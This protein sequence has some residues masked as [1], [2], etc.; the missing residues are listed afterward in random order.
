MKVLKVV[1]N[2]IVYQDSPMILRILFHSA[3]LKLLLIIYPFI[4]CAFH[5]GVETYFVSELSILITSVFKHCHCH[6]WNERYFQFIIYFEMC[7]CI[8]FHGSATVMYPVATV[9]SPPHV[10]SGRRRLYWSFLGVSCKA[11]SQICMRRKLVVG[12]CQNILGYFVKSHNTRDLG[13]MVVSCCFM[14]EPHCLWSDSM[15]QALFAKDTTSADEIG[16]WPRHHLLKKNERK[17]WGTKKE[18]AWSC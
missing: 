9:Y 14:L 10:E 18:S 4:Y 17:K 11:P 15:Y 3:D 2:F 12:N 8:S 7:S 13:I 5:C 6:F 1:Y 16:S